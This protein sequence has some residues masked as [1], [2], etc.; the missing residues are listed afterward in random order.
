ML[1]QQKRIRLCP[2]LYVLFDFLLERQ[3]RLVIDESESLDQKVSFFNQARS[4]F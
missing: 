4:P 2:E 3:A 1:E